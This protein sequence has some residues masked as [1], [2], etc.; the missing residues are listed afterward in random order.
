LG[1]AVAAAHALELVGLPEAQLNLAQATIHLALSPKSN[2]VTIAIGEAM[3]DVRAGKAGR[4]PAPLR[5]AHYAGAKRLQHGGGYRYPHD[6]PGGVVEQQY[7]PDEV[8]DRDY[9]RPYDRGAE[10]A[11]TERLAALRATVRGATDEDG[12]R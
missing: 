8:I 9:Y 5:D 3:A 11:A 1:V 6:S 12:E 7:P 2:A 4:V 10:R